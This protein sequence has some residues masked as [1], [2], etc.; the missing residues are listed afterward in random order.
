MEICRDDGRDWA[1]PRMVGWV[2]DTI[3]AWGG[4]VRGRCR[5][6]WGES[7]V[8]IMYIGRIPRLSGRLLLSS[9]H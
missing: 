2:G 7:E 1:V 6:G 9:V 8:Q 4:V 5:G 3:G